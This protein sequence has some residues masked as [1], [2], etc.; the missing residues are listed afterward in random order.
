MSS[1]G[2][3]AVS[4]E[5]YLHFQQVG[6]AVHSPVLGAGQ[7]AA[8]AETASWVLTYNY[9]ISRM[10]M[11]DGPVY[12]VLLAQEPVQLEVCFSSSVEYRVKRLE[13]RVKKLEY[14]VKQESSAKLTN[15]RVS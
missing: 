15:K 13:Y 7:P 8:E 5:I 2:L 6:Q 3:K 1:Y 10:H 14:R 9:V 12:R 4:L 11:L